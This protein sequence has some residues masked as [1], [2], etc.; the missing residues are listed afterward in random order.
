MSLYVWSEV[1]MICILSSWC[2]CHPIISC[3]IK[4]QIGLTLLVPALRLTQVVMEKRLLNVACLLS[5]SPS[6]L[7]L[8]PLL[9]LLNFFCLTDQL[10][11]NYSTL[12]K[13]SQHQ[14]LDISVYLSVLWAGVQPTLDPYA[15]AFYSRPI[16]LT[17]GGEEFSVNDVCKCMCDCSVGWAE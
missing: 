13:I 9:L 10:F 14:S 7:L 12:G 4:I 2:H 5:L 17:L 3:F 11:S 1:Q 15:E 6:S 16:A 8:L